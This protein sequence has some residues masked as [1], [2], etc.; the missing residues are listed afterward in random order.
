MVF[1]TCYCISWV[2]SGFSLYKFMQYNNALMPNGETGVV[3]PQ[4][5]G[6]TKTFQIPDKGQQIYAQ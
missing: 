3:I 4:S 5:D 2:C 1:N 6:T